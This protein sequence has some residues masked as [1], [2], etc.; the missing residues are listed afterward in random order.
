VEQ[1]RL[2][3][4]GAAGGVAVTL[5]KL[6]AEVHSA[7]AVGRDRIGDV[8]IAELERFDAGAVV[9]THSAVATALSCVI[10]ELPPVHYQ[11]LAFGGSVRVAPYATFGSRELAE[12]VHFALEGR[13][14]ALMQN[15]GAVCFA[16]DC[17]AATELAL[18]LEWACDVYWRASLV[19]DP[20]V[21][22]EQELEGVVTAVTE[23]GYGQAQTR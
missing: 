12:N 16:S 6:G 19:G 2:S 3:P 20:R 7:G 17:G 11:M 4:A 15:H 23:R 5:G 14:A 1:I 21:L 9:H 13:S 8:L 22:S 10:E 18:L